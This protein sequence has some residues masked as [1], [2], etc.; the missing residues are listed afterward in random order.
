MAVIT[1]VRILVTATFLFFFLTHLTVFNFPLSFFL[2][3]VSNYIY[4]L[5][6]LSCTHFTRVSVDLNL[7]LIP[8]PPLL[9]VPLPPSPCPLPIS[10]PSPS[11]Y[12]LSLS[13]PF[14][15]FL[16]PSGVSWGPGRSHLHTRSLLLHLASL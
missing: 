10:S 1:Q 4:H 9:P 12:P 13:S 14:L 15:P 11:P 3:F 5:Y 8:S 2:C 16:P 7:F 6:M